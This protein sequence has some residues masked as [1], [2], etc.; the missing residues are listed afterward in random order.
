MNTAAEDAVHQ[1]DPAETSN[2]SRFATT[3]TIQQPDSAPGARSPS[4][5]GSPCGAGYRTHDAQEPPGKP[6]ALPTRGLPEPCP[7]KEMSSVLRF[8]LFSSCCERKGLSNAVIDA[9][10]PGEEE[11]LEVLCHSN[12]RCC[13]KCFKVRRGG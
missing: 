4:D 2:E 11:K 12:E 7:V 5:A 3:G 10:G 1:P 13:S 9:W 8:V 6:C